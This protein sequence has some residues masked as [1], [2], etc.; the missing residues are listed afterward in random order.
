[1]SKAKRTRSDLDSLGHFES[2][3]SGFFAMLFALTMIVGN[4]RAPAE[5]SLQRNQDGNGKFRQPL[6]VKQSKIKLDAAIKRI[7]AP[8]FQWCQFLILCHV[9]S[10]PKIQNLSRYC[11]LSETNKIHTGPVQVT[12]R[13][14]LTCAALDCRRLFSDRRLLPLGYYRSFRQHCYLGFIGRGNLP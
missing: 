12:A 7:S 10:H 13:R 8:G 6:L 5:R 11:L 9:V 14:W 1:M 4:D 2:C 3:S